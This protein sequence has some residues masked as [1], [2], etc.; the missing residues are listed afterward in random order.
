MPEQISVKRDGATFRI[1]MN[2]PQRHNSLPYEHL[3]E[4]LEAIGSVGDTTGIVVAAE[5][6]VFSAGHDFVDVAAHDLLGTGSLLQLCTSL[7]QVIESAPQVVIARDRPRAGFGD[8]GR[9][10][11]RRI[12]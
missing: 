10:P 12:L 5:G 4:L 8:H 2:R 7:M 9:M 6:P 1:T 3:T 11:T